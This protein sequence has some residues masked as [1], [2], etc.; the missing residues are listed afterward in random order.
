MQTQEVTV[1]IAGTTHTIN[2]P[3]DEVQTVVQAEQTL[4]Q[5]HLS[6]TKSHPH[7]SKE[8]RLVLCCLD[9]YS[10][11]QSLKT[12]LTRMQEDAKT[13]ERLVAQILEDADSIL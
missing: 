11:L 3:V 1:V 12:T 7:L 5:M 10:D 4:N 6:L 9:L 8:E 2:A 13:H